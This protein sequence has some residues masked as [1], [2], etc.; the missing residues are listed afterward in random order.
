[1]VHP[2][3]A[4]LAWAAGILDGEGCFTIS[5][6][7]NSGVHQMLLKVVCM[8]SRMCEK[9]YELFAGSH[10]VDG[11]GRPSW[12]VTGKKAASVIKQVYPFLVCKKDQADICLQ[13]AD[14]I[15][16]PGKRTKE[17]LYPQREPL[18]QALMKLHWAHREE[19]L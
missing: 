19:V 7:K 18:R 1:V 6:R 17:G 5:F 10:W 15:R 11:Q 13:F 3:I 8:D 4:G 2:N 9:L 16:A 14:T 12:Q